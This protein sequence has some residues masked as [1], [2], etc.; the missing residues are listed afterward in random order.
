MIVLRLESLTNNPGRFHRFLSLSPVVPIFYSKILTS[1]K[2]IPI[3]DFDAIY[4]SLE[5]RDLPV[6]MDGVVYKRA[7]YFYFLKRDFTLQGAGMLL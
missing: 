3:K 7:P 2:K 6:L 4:V 5:S 1:Q